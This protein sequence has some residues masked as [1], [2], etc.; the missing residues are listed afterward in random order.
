[1]KLEF[2]NTLVGNVYHVEI[3]VAGLTPEE[4]AAVN[5]FGEPV[6]DFGGSFTGSATRP[7][8]NVATYV[9][10]SLPARERRIL[11]QT[12]VKQVFSLDDF[13]DADIRAQV[14]LSRNKNLLFMAREGLLIRG[15]AFTG[16]Q[17]EARQG[18]PIYNGTSAAYTVND[19]LDLPPLVSGY[20]AGTLVG[21]AVELEA[22]ATGGSGSYTY[23]WR[24]L[25]G[26]ALDDS[27]FDDS[28]SSVVQFTPTQIGLYT[29]EGLVKD[30]V[31]D[32]A[33]EV[34]RIDVH[35]HPITISAGSNKTTDTGVPI[36]LAD[37]VVDVDNNYNTETLTYAWSVISGPDL[38]LGQFNDSTLLHPDFTPAMDGVYTL[39][40]V[41][42]DSKWPVQTDTLTVTSTT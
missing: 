9:T 13:E 20:D 31:L 6:I 25:A 36:A 28:S 42:D 41:V 34:F 29:I 40:L 39:Q 5:R 22:T 30:P 35:L 12:P 2:S 8:D 14:W 10:Y 19:A 11:S 38:S 7:G 27:Q 15:Y 23:V 3:G 32:A 18:P 17:A 26:P 24:I 16:E 21:E 1:M 37:A 33:P 4:Q